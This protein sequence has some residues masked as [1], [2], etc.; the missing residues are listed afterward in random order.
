MGLLIVF[1]VYAVMGSL[2]IFLESFGGKTPGKEQL[3]TQIGVSVFL[4][5]IAI[6]VPFALKKTKIVAYILFVLAIST[7]I[8]AGG[9]GI[10]GFAILIAAGIAAI[11]W[12]EKR[13]EGSD[14]QSRSESALDIL[15]SRYAKGEI[16]KDEFDSKRKDLE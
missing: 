3:F 16:T 14:V 10:I 4:Y 6:I 13:I 8:S 11:R 5:I 12:K 15:K 9:F 2:A 1:G 7:L